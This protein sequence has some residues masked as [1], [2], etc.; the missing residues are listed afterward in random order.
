MSNK[1]Q[2]NQQSGTPAWKNA[3]QKQTKSKDS[4]QRAAEAT[5]TPEGRVKLKMH[6]DYRDVAKKGDEW[7]TDEEKGAE[8]VRLGRAEY[9]KTPKAK[10]KVEAHIHTDHES[11]A[12][13]SDD[14]TTGADANPPK[15]DDT[16]QTDV[17]KTDANP[18]TV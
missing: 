3:Q 13:D 18:A 6:S 8:L 10:A 11:D 15:G 5:P 17:D 4:D 12:N 7:E 2:K 14:D 16:A 9:V 1:S